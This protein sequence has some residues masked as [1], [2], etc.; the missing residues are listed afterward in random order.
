VDNKAQSF[1]SQGADIYIGCVDTREARRA[2][3]NH[4]V[5]ASRY[6]TAWWL[7][8]GNSAR[9]GQVILGSCNRGVIELPS[10]AHL[11]PEM[12]DS[13]LDAKDDMPS[14]SL[15]EALA[16]Q[17]LFTNRMIADTAMNLMWQLFRYG[18]T[19][20]HGAFVNLEVMRTNPLA[21]DPVA[22]ERM[23]YVCKD[24]IKEAA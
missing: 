19:K 20:V 12:I 4:W 8:C 23:G 5:N 22:W 9:A 7:D 1:R 16:K 24:E 21:I 14:C 15:P 18:E 17:D 2:I 6:S 13:G 10:A 3:Y 11:F